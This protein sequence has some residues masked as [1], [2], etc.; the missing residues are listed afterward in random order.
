M[1]KKL[2][3]VK[4]LCHK[5]DGLLMKLLTI[6]SFRPVSFLISYGFFHKSEKRKKWLIGVKSAIAVY[7]SCMYDLVISL[8]VLHL[9]HNNSMNLQLMYLLL[10]ILYNLLI[11]NYCY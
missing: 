11:P 6:L 2:N 8:R 5:A 7:V 4:Q 3:D 10:K 1:T 9:S